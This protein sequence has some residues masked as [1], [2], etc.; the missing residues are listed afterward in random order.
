MVNAAHLAD[1][2]LSRPASLCRKNGPTAQTR[3][4][5]GRLLE[6]LLEPMPQQEE[7]AIGVVLARSGGRF[8]DAMEREAFRLHLGSNVWF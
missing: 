1:L 4:L 3:G 6:A 2:P 5:W 8:T 7:R